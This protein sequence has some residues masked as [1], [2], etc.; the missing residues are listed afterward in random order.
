MTPGEI[1]DQACETKLCMLSK[2]YLLLL[3]IAAAVLVF[4][5]SWNF[6][7]SPPARIN[8]ILKGINLTGLPDSAEN[9]TIEKKKGGF[10]N[11]QVIFIGFNASEIDIINF[12][13]SSLGPGDEP[14]TLASFHLGPTLSSWTRWDATTDGRVYHLNRNYTSVWLVVDDESDTI[15]LYVFLHRPAWFYKIK[16]YIPLIN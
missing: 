5:L 1:R 3:I 2:N 16:K 9:L 11:S 10:F 7:R 13:N 6:Y 14:G 4:V 8:S 15:Y 12:L